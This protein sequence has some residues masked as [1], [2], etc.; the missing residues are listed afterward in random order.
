MAIK[1]HITYE[2][3]VITDTTHSVPGTC[4]TARLRPRRAPDPMF[5]LALVTV[6]RANDSLWNAMHIMKSST[7]FVLELYNCAFGL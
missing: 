6:E 2:T 4:L 7:F 3:I 5:Y 1:G